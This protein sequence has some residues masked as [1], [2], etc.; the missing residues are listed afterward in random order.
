M[1]FAASLSHPMHAVVAAVALACAAP[2]SATIGLAG[3]MSPNP[4]TWGAPVTFVGTLGDLSPSDFSCAPNQGVNAACQVTSAYFANPLLT[5]D[6]GDGSVWTGFEPTVSVEHLYLPGGM[7][8]FQPTVTGSADLVM[9]ITRTWDEDHVEFV[10]VF[11]MVLVDRGYWGT[12]YDD[13]GQMRYQ[14]IEIWVWE[15]VFVRTDE[16]HTIQQMFASEQSVTSF[17]GSAELGTLTMVPEPGTWWTM[18]A[19]LLLLAVAKSRGQAAMPGRATSG[20]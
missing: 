13:Y 11:E 6:F 12:Y 7:S 15:E 4:G 17:G 19:G 20:G 2:A 5:L 10:P 18:A 9:D 16:V 14:W 8:T 1:N 3:S